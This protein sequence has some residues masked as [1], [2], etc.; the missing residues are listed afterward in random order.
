M[1][2]TNKEIEKLVK[3]DMYQVFLLA[4]PC[5]IPLSFASHTWFVVNKMGVLSRYEIVHTVM[6]RSEKS[7]G[8]LAMNFLPS[9]SGLNII[10][11]YFGKFYFKA[12]LVNFIEGGEESSA[13]GMIDFIENS[14]NIYSHTKEYVYTGPNSNTYTQWILDQFPEFKAKLPWNAVGKNYEKKV[15]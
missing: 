13:K 6:Y 10:P 11:F 14:P 12:N 4:S 15:L 7:W 8:H 3:S 1:N 9:F 2:Q 5:S